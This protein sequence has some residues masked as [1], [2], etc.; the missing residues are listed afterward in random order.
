MPQEGLFMN[1]NLQRWEFR[2]EKAFPF[3]T[4]NNS[5]YGI[6]AKG[7]II[8]GDDKN[9]AK[10]DSAGN[11]RFSGEATYRIS[12]NKYAIQCDLMP[13]EGLFMNETQQRWEFRDEKA[14]PF[15]TINNSSYDIATAG[16]LQV[17][18]SISTVAGNI[19]FN[20]GIFQGFDG[21]I[22]RNFTTTPVGRMQDTVVNNSNNILLVNDKLQQ[23]INT[24][25]EQINELK[26]LVKDLYHPE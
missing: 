16:G 10:I 21:T 7:G 6:A 11:L 17:G 26:I 12:G 20:A 1:E 18:N 24:L 4:I 3:F 19:R 14:F 15:F 23:Q 22:W 2:D 8:A 5:N 13:Q 9:N 25:Q